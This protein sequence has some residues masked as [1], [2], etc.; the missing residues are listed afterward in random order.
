[1]K[2]ENYTLY[3]DIIHGLLLYLCKCIEDTL[4][5]RKMEW[6]DEEGT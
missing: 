5:T 4:Y 6:K 3:L 2:G 1:M